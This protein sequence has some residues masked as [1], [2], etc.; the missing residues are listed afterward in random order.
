MVKAASYRFVAAIDAAGRTTR[1]TGEFQ[2][3]DRLHEIITSGASPA[4]ET[5]FAG[6]RVFVRDARSG[7]WS[8]PTTAAGTPAAPDPRLAFA[9]LEQA[10]H[11]SQTGSVFR[12][13]LPSSVA[14]QLVQTQTSTAAVTGEGTATAAAEGISHLEFDLRGA[15]GG[16]RIVLD[17]TAIGRGPSVTQ[18]I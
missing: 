16:V 8:Q 15:S 18:P 13:S 7:Q 9:W 11:V 6:G 14:R 1:V 12:F 2:A 17:Y 5:V 10:D 4:V 3:P